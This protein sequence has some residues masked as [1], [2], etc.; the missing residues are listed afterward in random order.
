VMVTYS[1]GELGGPLVAVDGQIPA[2]PAAATE[3]LRARTV[4]VHGAGMWEQ[5]LGINLT[6]H[7][8]VLVCCV[9]MCR[10]AARGC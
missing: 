8:C 2:G 1:R 6:G 5:L 7:V 3:A 4:R 10:I 9:C